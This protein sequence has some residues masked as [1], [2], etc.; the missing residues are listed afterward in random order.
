MSIERTVESEHKS[1]SPLRIVLACVF[2]L[3]AIGYMTAIVSGQ[4]RPD[5]R[6]DA[7]SLALFGLLGIGIVLLLNPRQLEGLKL[8]EMYGF[9]LEI[10]KVRET[11]SEQATQLSNMSLILPLLLP[12][13]ERVCLVKLA[14]G[15]AG[16]EPG[17]HDMRTA[18]R[19]LRSFDLIRM[20]NGKHVGELKDGKRY[21]LEG[22]VELTRSGKSWAATITE[23]ERRSADALVDESGE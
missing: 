21:D 3:L 15:A 4:L 2:G 8:L 22:F 14:S 6:L 17:S 13:A 16:D 23:I 5:H 11:Q 12:K 10:Q 9:K 18:L 19:R 7:T 1:L 20:R